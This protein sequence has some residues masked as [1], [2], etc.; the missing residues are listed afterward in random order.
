M[1]VYLK[2]DRLLVNTSD[3]Y[4][5]NPQRN[6]STGESGNE[7]LIHV[8]L[9]VKDSGDLQIPITNDNIKAIVIVS[10]RS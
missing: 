4:I 9:Q 10:T 6:M 5:N 7:D 1:K 8:L 2:M 3:Q